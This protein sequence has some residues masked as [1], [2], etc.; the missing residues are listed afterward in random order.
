MLKRLFIFSVFSVLLFSCT[1][2]PKPLETTELVTSGTWRMQLDIDGAIVP[3]TM[4]IDTNLNVNFHNASE[5][6]NSGQLALK[7]DSFYL[8]MPIYGTY[9]Q[10]VL[11]EPS[12][13]NGHWHNI[14]KGADYLIPFTA[15]HTTSEFAKY[16]PI[17]QTVKY[18]VEFS[19]NTDDSYPAV[20]VF[21]IENGKAEGTFLT[22]TGDYRFLEGYSTGNNLSLSCFDG[23]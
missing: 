15:S 18:Q 10:G 20:G 21:S 12:K 6:I 22:E 13:L 19:P 14:Q 4:T 8:E 5:V 3:V 16:A 9:F 17:E 7:N 1:N 11:S 23:S 2:E